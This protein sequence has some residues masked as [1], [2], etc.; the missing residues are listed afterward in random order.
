MGEYLMPIADQLY[1]LVTVNEWALSLSK[2][3]PN[4]PT[5]GG[6]KLLVFAGSEIKSIETEYSSADFKY[7]EASKTIEKRKQGAIGP[8]VCN[9]GQARAITNYFTPEEGVAS[10]K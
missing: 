8:F 2:R 7:L 5:Y 10:G 1:A 3:W 6:Y 4:A 9:I